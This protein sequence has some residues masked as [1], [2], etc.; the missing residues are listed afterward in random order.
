MDQL[1][2]ALD[3]SWQIFWSST[4]MQPLL[5]VTDQNS[6]NSPW[7]RHSLFERQMTTDGYQALL[8]I[9]C[10]QVITSSQTWYDSF[11]TLYDLAQVIWITGS[12]YEPMI[13]STWLSH[14]SS[15]EGRSCT[16]TARTPIQGI[17]NRYMTRAW[18]CHILCSFSPNWQTFYYYAKE[19]IWRSVLASNLPL[20]LTFQTLIHIAGQVHML[21]AAAQSA[22]AVKLMR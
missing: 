17:S 22:H 20:E 15:L 18:S 19:I 3:W 2:Q 12:Y 5:A 16:S 8:L 14:S 9:L 11:L 10:L 21:I 1:L 7:W 6:W 13:R 4:R